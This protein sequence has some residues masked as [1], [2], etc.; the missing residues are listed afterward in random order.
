MIRWILVTFSAEE[1]GDELEEKLR[2]AL[3]AAGES[4]LVSSPAGPLAAFERKAAVLDRI[5][6]ISVY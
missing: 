2:R 3:P 6:A 1:S 5:P 4:H